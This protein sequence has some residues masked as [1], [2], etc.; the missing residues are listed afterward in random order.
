MATALSTSERRAIQ[1]LYAAA[2]T[3]RGAHHRAK[4]LLRCVLEDE[5]QE[6]TGYRS[7]RCQYR[8]CLICCWRYSQRLT[9]RY[10]RKIEKIR[11]DDYRLG[12]LTLTI[13]NVSSLSSELYKG[14]AANQKS[15]FRRAPFKDRMVAG[16]SKIETDFNYESQDFHPHTHMIL[17]YE[18]C[19]PQE[20]IV[21]AWCDLIYPQPSHYVLSDVP[22]HEG[23]P[24]LAW[25]KKIDPEAIR[26]AVNYL[27]KYRPIKEAEAFA[28][29][30]CAVRK[31]RLVQSYGALRGRTGRA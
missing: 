1:R 11:C 25:I 12:F 24:C 8:N 14:L 22:G 16:V 7:W 28:E 2:L 6:I 30:D 15:L 13:P 17:I 3:A 23:E 5:R 9:R 19:I 31:I 18:Q 27:F 10:V 4:Q 29:Y 26:R 21:E 20:E